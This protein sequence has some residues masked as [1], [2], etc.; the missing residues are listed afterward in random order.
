MSLLIK[1]TANLIEY[2]SLSMET[3]DVYVT[4]YLTVKQGRLLILFICICADKTRLEFIH[5]YRK[6][7]NFY[8]YSYIHVCFY[9]DINT[10]CTCTCCTYTY[11]FIVYIY[12]LMSFGIAITK[13]AVAK[14]HTQQLYFGYILTS[15]AFDLVRPT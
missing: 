12:Q 4:T 9:T 8:T 10:S 7:Q 11:P 13:T 3:F 14:P 1:N 5:A 15:V 2:R 6:C